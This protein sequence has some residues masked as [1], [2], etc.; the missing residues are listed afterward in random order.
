MERR[1]RRQSGF[2]YLGL[3]ALIAIMGLILMTATRVWSFSEQRDKERQLLYVGDQFRNAIGA[4]FAFGSQYPLT[5]QQLLQDDRSP[6]P[7]RY[8]RQIY[9]DPITGDTDWNLIKDPS[10]VGIMGVASKS[11]LVPIKRRRFA[12]IEFGF[13]NKDCYCDWQFI[14]SPSFGDGWHRYSVPGQSIGPAL[15]APAAPPVITTPRK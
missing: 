11:K 12:D 8:L 9:R 2:T 13:A 15:P 5:L 1:L 4:Y 3:L 6:V 10:G 14:Y 7:R